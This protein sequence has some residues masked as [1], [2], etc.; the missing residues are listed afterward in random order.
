MRH[1]INVS[2]TPVFHDEL[3]RICK[4]YGFVNLCEICTALLR[5]FVDR[6]NNAEQNKGR[7]LERNEDLIK[8]MF[9]EFENW[10][11]TPQPDIMYKRHQRR[12]PDNVPPR[13][14]RG[15]ADDSSD[16]LEDPDSSAEDSAQICDG[17]SVYDL[18]YLEKSY[19]P[20]SDDDGEQ[21]D[22]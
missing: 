14:P 3:Q 7:R 20:G 4:D 15:A 17:V 9:A 2:I 8:Q 1:R 6:V 11:P 12:N 22:Y 18:D 19:G 10:E 13:K 16:S 21:Y 5:V